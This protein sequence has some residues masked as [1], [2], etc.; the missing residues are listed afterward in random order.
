MPKVTFD[1]DPVEEA[2][3]AVLHRHQVGHGEGRYSLV[4]ST[5]HRETGN[6]ERVLRTNLSLHRAR[7]L[8][9]KLEAIVSRLRPHTMSRP[10]YWMKLE[11]YQP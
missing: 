5:W 3:R 2:T 1:L 8:E 11:P 10:V 7:K 6:I 9:R 4:K